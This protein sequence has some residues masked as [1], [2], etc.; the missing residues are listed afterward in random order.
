MK[1]ILY[2]LFALLTFS[3]VLVACSD[4]DD[5]AISYGATPEIEA[6]GVYTGTFARVQDGTT[7]TLYT[8][9]TVTITPTDSAYCA[10]IA[11]DCDGDFTFNGTSVVNITHAGHGF[12][13][14]NSSAS[15]GLG[16]AFM[17]RIDENGNLTS[18]F[19][20]QQ[21]SGRLTYTYHYNITAAKG[22]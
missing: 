22:Q 12:I 16:T 15:N 8:T 5:D 4:D 13:F 19:K 6:A 11:F 1:K 9:G 2:S 21:K 20:I 17:G 10:D 18:Y 14:E 3:C 7:D